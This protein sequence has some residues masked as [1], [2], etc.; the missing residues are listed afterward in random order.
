M[1]A[2]SSPQ[3]NALAASTSP[4]K[5]MEAADTAASSSSVRP[6]LVQR[7]VKK[8]RFVPM[9]QPSGP[10]LPLEVERLKHMTARERVEEGY[11]LMKSMNTTKG[12]S[13]FRS[14]LPRDPYDL[15]EERVVTHQQA[16]RNHLFEQRHAELLRAHGMRSGSVDRSSPAAAAGTEKSAPRTRSSSWARDTTPRGNYL[17]NWTSMPQCVPRL[18]VDPTPG[19]GFYTPAL[20]FVGGSH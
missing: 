11:R 1:T 6:R 8:S 3:E 10:P 4:R 5:P 9:P 7:P 19:P 20:H 14:A 15:K 2:T 17:Y 18:H 12:T 16:V 13:A